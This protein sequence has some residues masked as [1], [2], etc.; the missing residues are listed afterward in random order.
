M[1]Q[2]SE[3]GS[4][5]RPANKHKRE[6]AKKMNK[7]NRVI[8]L[9]V[10]PD[11]FTGAVLLKGKDA[12]SARVV[13]TSRRVELPELE[14]WVARHTGEQDVLVLEAS[15]NAFAVAER[16]RVLQRPVV[17]LDRHRARQIR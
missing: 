17:I 4:D 7:S 9:D 6:E 14:K 10:H 2:L 8:G 11:S 3:T 12:A 1:R 13:S 5:L 16:L 15:G